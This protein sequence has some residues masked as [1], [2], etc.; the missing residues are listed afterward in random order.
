[1]PPRRYFRLFEWLGTQ[2]APLATGLPA[3]LLGEP[4][5]EKAAGKLQ[6][7]GPETPSR[8]SAVWCAV[9]RQDTFLSSAT[10]PAGL[11][12]ADALSPFLVDLRPIREKRFFFFL[13][14]LFLAFGISCARAAIQYFWVSLRT[15]QRSKLKICTCVCVRKQFK[16]SLHSW[17][18]CTL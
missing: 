1:M 4:R 8:I 17:E 9:S 15:K 12:M 5:W 7:V 13:F 2:G 3:E 10:L 11:V 16:A 18:K 14:L 6:C